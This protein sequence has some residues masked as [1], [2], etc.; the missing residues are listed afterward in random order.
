MV[1]ARKQG[2]SLSEK[3]DAFVSLLLERLQKEGKRT[4]SK[5]KLQKALE[6]AING[7]EGSVPF[8][9]ELVKRL[10]EI[11][12]SAWERISD[13]KEGQISVQQTQF[14][15]N[16]SAG[17]D[18][19]LEKATSLE[20]T[21]ANK[22]YGN[23]VVSA[24]EP[25][26]LI[27]VLE[28]WEESKE[29]SDDPTLEEALQQANDFVRIFSGT[30]LE[31][32]TA[33]A[34]TCLVRS[35]ASALLRVLA[36]F[37]SPATNEPQIDAAKSSSLLEGVDRC[38]MQLRARLA[39]MR[40]ISAWPRKDQS[41]YSQCAGQL[42]RCY[43]TLLLNQSNTSNDPAGVSSRVAALLTWLPGQSAD[44]ALSCALPL[45][46]DAVSSNSQKNTQQ[47]ADTAMAVLRASVGV[48]LSQ[49]PAL[50]A[51]TTQAK[52]VC[53]LRLGKHLSPHTSTKAPLPAHTEQALSR[54]PAPVSLVSYVPTLPSK[55]GIGPEAPNFATAIRSHVLKSATVQE[56][57]DLYTTLTSGVSTLT[58]QNDGEEEGESTELVF[59][60][61]KGQVESDGKD[62]GSESQSE[63]ESRE[64][65]TEKE[66]E[67]TGLLD[68]IAGLI[69]T[70]EP[71]APNTKGT[72]RKATESETETPETT[73][74]G[75]TRRV[76]RSRK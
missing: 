31:S 12:E 56:T 34:I 32:P 3:A 58:N 35:L 73:E 2:V 8:K 25:D 15:L 7:L 38:L 75:R 26:I 61:D 49:A 69:D 1:K 36:H 43:A 44:A 72:K 59:Y 37:N 63:E 71:E 62:E 53:L 57:L 11:V 55:L 40:P 50:S 52:F 70:V 28:A 18:A 9:G 30:L 33:N 16:C 47:L 45:V 14:D 10:Q 54:I 13:E 24:P 68:T 22:F 17:V 66:S 5:A 42:F 6:K 65:D 19:A 4:Q 51:P 39:S 76:T 64:D 29:G 23:L 60:V 48:C 27:P 67:E 46:A 41:A 20:S 21:E 74:A